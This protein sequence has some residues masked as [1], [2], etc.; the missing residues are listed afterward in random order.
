M[1]KRF[2]TIQLIYLPFYLLGISQLFKIIELVTLQCPNIED[3]DNLNLYITKAEVIN[4][5]AIF[6]ILYTEDKNWKRR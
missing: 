6:N 2:T 5:E 3:K 1:V 4:Q